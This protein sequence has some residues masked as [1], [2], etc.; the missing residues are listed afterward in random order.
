MSDRVARVSEFWGHRVWGKKGRQDV[1]LR[2]S[3]DDD[4]TPEVQM[5]RDLVGVRYVLGDPWGLSTPAG[6][7]RCGQTLREVLVSRYRDPKNWGGE[8]GVPLAVWFVLTKM[9]A[10][11]GSKE[12]KDVPPYLVEQR[13]GMALSM[14]KKMLEASGQ[15]V[16]DKDLMM[17]FARFI[18]GNLGAVASYVGCESWMLLG[19]D[20]VSEYMRSSET[21]ISKHPDRVS[22]L[23][24]ATENLTATGRA[25]RQLWTSRVE[26]SGRGEEPGPWETMENGWSE[27]RFVHLIEEVGN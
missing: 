20:Q 2:Y 22:A 12:L 27:G 19:D 7:D 10:E 6:R 3:G 1:E 13:W 9:P 24:V 17:T 11:V 18:C 23:V 16:S 5:R 21:S 15:R 25:V 4:L 14:K 8:H 26:G